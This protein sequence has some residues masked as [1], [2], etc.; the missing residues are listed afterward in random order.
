M[1]E[2]SLFLHGFNLLPQ[3]GPARLSRICKQFDSLKE[4][5]HLSKEQLVR[6]GI[7]PEVAQA[8]TEKREQI[9]LTEEKSKLAKE[10]I[11]ILTYKDPLYPK[12]LLEIPKLP[13]L[14]YYKGNMIDAEELSLAV[15]G[16][17][18]ISNYGRIVIPKLIVPLVET[19]ITIISGMAFGVD[20][21]AHQIS[22]DAGK[23]TIAVLGGGLDW[24][25]IYPKHHQLLAEK[26]LE[27]GGA[28]LSEYPI[29]TPSLKHHF[30]SRNRIISGMSVATIIIESDLKSGSLITAKHAL[31]QNRQV[32]AVPGPIYSETSQGSNNLI[33]MGA[34]PL[35]EASDVLED[36]NLK[37]LP[38]QQETQIAFGDSPAESTIL[39]LLSLEPIH[40]NELIKQAEL[41]SP[42]VI[43]TLTFLEMK[44]KVKNLGGQ[45]Y[46][47]SR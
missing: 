9:N 39:K 40:I 12:L 17:R 7:E 4:A 46:I 36:L 31:E 32:Y 3:F 15:V 10:Q 35:T 21:G 34:K 30:V 43:S 14:L 22:I 11:K 20:S 5:Y 25:S 19:G 6:T 44:G 26:I 27:N 23:R 41:E 2:N 37:N 33:K 18:K 28:L 8:F 38:Q 29:G 1:D 24:A 42:E 45:Q 47:L 13:P 16:T